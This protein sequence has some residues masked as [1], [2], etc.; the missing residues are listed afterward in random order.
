MHI[1]FLHGSLFCIC[2]L[3]LYCLL[4]PCKSTRVTPCG[5]F[6]GWLHVPMPHLDQQPIGPGPQTIM[7][8]WSLYKTLL[9][10]SSSVEAWLGQWLKSA[11]IRLNH[12]G[13][14]VFYGATS[15]ILSSSCSRAHLPLPLP[16]T[17]LTWMPVGK[18]H[19]PQCRGQWQWHYGCGKGSLEW[20]HVQ[21]GE[22]SVISQAYGDQ[23]LQTDSTQDAYP[24]PRATSLQAQGNPAEEEVDYIPACFVT[25]PPW[26][27]QVDHGWRDL[28]WRNLF[29]YP[30]NESVHIPQKAPWPFLDVLCCYLSI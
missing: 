27:T 18:L 11:S 14:Y 5:P 1:R 19:Q 26:S 2:N 22:S 28:S 17:L 23:I 8:L 16:P 15:H 29:A 7:P 25:E 10:P 4:S 24:L 12:E 21:V 9:W 20:S 30:C 6:F 13:A 3:S